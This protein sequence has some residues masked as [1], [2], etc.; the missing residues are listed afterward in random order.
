MGRLSYARFGW[1]G[2]DVYVYMGK[3][4]LACCGCF[5]GEQWNF[6]S[7]QTMVDHLEKHIAAGYN[8]PPT[9]I[10][11]LWLDDKSNFP[12]SENDPE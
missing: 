4:A 12:Y 3:D 5:I 10:P 9:L 6:Y 11:E 7:T 1:D 8:V 2:S